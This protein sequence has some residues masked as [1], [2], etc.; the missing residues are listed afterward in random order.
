M[1][2]SYRA[3]DNWPDKGGIEFQQLGIRYR[4]DLDLALKEIDCQICPSE[5][6]VLIASAN[7]VPTYTSI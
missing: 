4:E 1:N 7:L 5:K 6:V 3:P 2:T